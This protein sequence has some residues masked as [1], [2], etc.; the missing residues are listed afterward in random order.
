MQVTWHG[1]GDYFASVMQDGQNRSV[2]I[3]QLSSR[4]SQL[5][6][7]RSKGLIQC[8]LFHPVR[9][10]FFIAVSMY[11]DGYINY[12]VTLSNSITSLAPNELVRGYM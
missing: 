4:R 2:V 3:H 9:P 5:P 6:L 12:S 11:C 10:I 7:N 8:V 1:K